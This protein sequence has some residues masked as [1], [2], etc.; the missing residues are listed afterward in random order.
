FLWFSQGGSSKN[1][2]AR[3]SDVA[4]CRRIFKM[5]A[6]CIWPA[7]SGGPSKA[8]V[9]GQTQATLPKQPG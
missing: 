7:V 3:W 9:A 8:P 1:L 6:D 5:A 2:S 4:Y